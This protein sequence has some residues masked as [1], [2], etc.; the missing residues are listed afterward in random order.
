MSKIS[1]LIFKNAKHYITSPYGARNTISTS[2]GKTSSFHNG[3]DYGTHNKKLP[4]YAI[5]DGYI[6]AAGT[7]SSDGAKYVWVIYP[8][9]K[10]AFL[11]YHLDSIS[12]KAGQKV[13]KGTKLGTTGKTGKAT[14]IHLHLG[15][16]PLTNL[17]AAQVTAMTWALLRSCSYTNPEK[18]NY[19]APSVA[20][21]KNKYETGTYT[22]SADLL[23]VRT[24]AGTS[25]A[26]KTFK[27]LTANAQAQIKKL[28][29]GNPANGLVKGC[30]C[31]V[32]QV[33]DNW[34]KIP[35]GWIC[36]DYC[37]RV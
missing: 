8:R 13:T 20:V 4:Q 28:N 16:R 14:G 2:A 34:G 37:K 29:K 6:F 21:S 25:Y 18:V 11:H 17:T 15:I 32:S 9:I 5:E 30:T 26:K 12:V 22:V 23:N 1:D 27:Q 10:L 7:S 24:G 36:L 31:T 33:K 35:S 3:T 19:T